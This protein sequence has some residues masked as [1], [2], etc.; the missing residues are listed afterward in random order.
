MLSETKTALRITTDAYDTEI[1]SLLSAAARDLETAGV[2]VPGAVD[3][4]EEDGATVDGSTI[5]DPLVV[6]AMITYVRMHFGSPN[7]YDRL[8][9]AYET[10]K[11]TLMHAAEY[12]NYER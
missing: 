1:A 6:R 9:E 12:T 8:A 5:F 3:I 4:Y 10:Q 11:C 7:D 2:I